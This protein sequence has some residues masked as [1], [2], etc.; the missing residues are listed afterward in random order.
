M[1]KRACCWQERCWTAATS[2]ERRPKSARPSNS[3]TPADETYPLLGRVLLA[4]RDFPK[5]ISEL[6]GQ[7][8]AA[9]QAQAD[10][11]ASLAFA[12]IGNGN[13]KDARTAIDA[14]LVAKPQYF[15][16]QIAQAQLAASENNLPAALEM[17]N[18]ALAQTSG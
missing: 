7:K 10:L 18:A 14:A 15:R 5:M 17:V 2:Q 3:S 11:M 6:S 8:L 13:A 4:Q 9:P 16:A 12:Y 1:A